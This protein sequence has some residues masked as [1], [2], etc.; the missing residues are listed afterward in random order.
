MKP[1]L[2]VWNTEDL[3]LLA[4]SLDPNAQQN[5]GISNSSGSRAFEL[6]DDSSWDN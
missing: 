2:Q 3:T 1:A 6:D 5:P 4:G